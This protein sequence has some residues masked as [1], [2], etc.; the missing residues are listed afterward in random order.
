MAI[1]VAEGMGVDAALVCAIIEVSSQWSVS[2]NSWE[3]EPW[4][5]QI[6]PNDFKGG[7]PEYVAMGTR[8]GLMQFLGSKAKAGGYPKISADLGD[9]KTNIEAGCTIL[10]SIMGQGTP[11]LLAVLMNWYGFDKRRMAEYTIAVLPRFREFVAARPAAG[12]AP[13]DSLP[14]LP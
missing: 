5:L 8:F 10:K 6:H 11:S 2:L 4:L 1:D 9:P 3:P 12:T 13:V 14:V 7:E